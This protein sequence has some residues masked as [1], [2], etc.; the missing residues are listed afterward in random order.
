MSIVERIIIIFGGVF[1]IMNGFTSFNL[2]YGN[3]KK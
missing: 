3:K 2:L 1:A